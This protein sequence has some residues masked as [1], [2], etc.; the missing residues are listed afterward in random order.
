M[1]RARCGTLR[2][3]RSLEGPCAE[4]ARRRRLF[5]GAEGAGWLAG[6]T[7]L[8]ALEM[9]CCVLLEGPHFFKGRHRRAP[10]AK[11]FGLAVH[12]HHLL[13]VQVLKTG[14][15]VA[16]HDNSDLRSAHF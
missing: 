7:S 9:L 12:P 13:L 3:R 16:W 11:A 1:L 2:R 8:S 10:S 4:G 5:A 15:G 14:H 6:C